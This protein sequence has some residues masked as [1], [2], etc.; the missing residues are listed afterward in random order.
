MYIYII[1]WSFHF[2]I[3]PDFKPWASYLPS[4]SLNFL[5]R[6]WEGTY[7]FNDF[8][9]C[10]YAYILYV[11]KTGRCEGWEK[12]VEM[13][14]GQFWQIVKNSMN[15]NKNN[16]ESIYFHVFFHF[17][18]LKG[19]YSKLNNII[20]LVVEFLGGSWRKRKYSGQS[21]SRALPWVFS[22]KWSRSWMPVVQRFTPF[23]LAE[24]I[25]YC[26]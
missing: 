10:V 4:L 21:R 8:M 6:K 25:F 17:S 18:F 12:Q 13:Y 2:G 1:A 23:L 9:Y 22:N 5:F 20:Q 7:Q 14:L 11:R 15:P 19:Q 3:R 24:L 16:S 26:Y